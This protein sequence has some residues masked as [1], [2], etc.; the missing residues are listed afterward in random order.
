MVFWITVM[1]AMVF[2]LIGRL[3]GDILALRV[4]DTLVGGAI[5]FLDALKDYVWDRVDWLAGGEAGRHPVEEAREVDDKLRAVTREAA[6]A[7]NQALLFGRFRT[8]LDRFVTGF[9]ALNYYARH[10]AGPVNRSQ[11]LEDVDGR[12]E[13][14]GEAGERIAG[15]LHSLAESISGGVPPEVRE[16]EDLMERL[17]GVDSLSDALHYLWRINRTLDEVAKTPGVGSNKRAIHR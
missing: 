6:T 15:N 16:L 17:E 3:T 12:G 8:D 11:H 4:E 1:L 14:L 2:D 13:L 9:M 5:D 7:R 10:L